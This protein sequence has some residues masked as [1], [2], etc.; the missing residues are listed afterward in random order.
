MKLRRTVL[1]KRISVFMLL[2]LLL[3]SLIISIGC[4]KKEAIKISSDE[5]IL[6]ERVMAYWNYRVKQELDKSYEFEDPIYKKGHS[7]VSYIKRFGVD[8]V[9]LKEVKISGLQMED[10]A[11]RIDLKMRVEVRAPGARAPLKTEADR[12][13]RWGKIEGMWYHVIDEHSARSD[14]KNK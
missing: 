5:E 14:D 12:S 4:V 8:P 2:L 1:V 10:A 7:L 6:R 11:A 3:L 9:R 13:D